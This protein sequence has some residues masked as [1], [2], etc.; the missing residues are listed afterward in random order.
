MILSLPQTWEIFKPVRRKQSC[1][2]DK[3]LNAKQQADRR[4]LKSKLRKQLGGSP[5]LSN[6]AKPKAEKDV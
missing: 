4:K 5:D 3:G 2:E 1:R 6:D